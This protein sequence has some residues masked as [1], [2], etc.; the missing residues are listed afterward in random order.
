MGAIPLRIIPFFMQRIASVLC[1]ELP[2]SKSYLWCISFLQY[3]GF[4]LLRRSGSLCFPSSPPW[5]GSEI[6]HVFSGGREFGKKKG[7]AAR[8]AAQKCLVP[9][10][11]SASTENLL[12]L[13]VRWG[14]RGF[15]HVAICVLSYDRLC[16][17][18][19]RTCALMPGSM[20][21]E[22]CMERQG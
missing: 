19:L 22:E 5:G 15:G 2:A 8:K 9:S 17:R 12:G 14:M 6:R 20:H 3:S 16:I 21:L 1:E 10:C 18:M 7:L 11:P 13:W 4:A